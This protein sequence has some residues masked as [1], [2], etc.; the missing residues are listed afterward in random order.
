MEYCDRKNVIKREQYY[1]D[2]FKPIYNILKVAGSAL[3]FVHSSEAI[4]KIRLKATGRKHTIETLTKMMGRTH[5]E[6]TKNKIKNILQTK[7]TRKKMINA[8][9][10]RTG[11]KVSNETR[12]KMKSAQINRDWVPVAGIKVEVKDLN[13]NEIIVYDS[14]NKAAETLNIPKGTIARRVKLNIEKPYKKRYIIK[15]YKN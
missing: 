4:E 11:V 7:E 2:T 13:T 14:I 8:A 9:L 3:G 1:I 10:K 6:A 12:A 15:A 5:S